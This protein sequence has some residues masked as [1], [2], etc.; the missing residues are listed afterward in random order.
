MSLQ[1][2]HKKD[3][4]DLKGYQ[5]IFTHHFGNMSDRKRAK[6]AEGWD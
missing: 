4:R 6:E 3:V 5:T 2:D 1:G